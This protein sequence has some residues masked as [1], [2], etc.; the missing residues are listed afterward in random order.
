MK[1]IIEW[2]SQSHHQ[3]ISALSTVQ[4]G[5]PITP[6]SSQTPTSN[7]DKVFVYRKWRCG[8]IQFMRR[9]FGRNSSQMISWRWINTINYCNFVEKKSFIIVVMLAL[10]ILSLWIKRKQVTWFKVLFNGASCHSVV[11]SNLLHC[12]GQK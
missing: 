2:V 12:N 6:H 11:F 7:S 10:A 9:V 3:C 5:V 8:K 1:D 4:V